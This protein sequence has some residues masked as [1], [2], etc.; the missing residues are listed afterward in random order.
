MDTPYTDA[1][2][3]ICLDVLQHVS[4]DTSLVDEDERFKALVAKIRKS[5]KRRIQTDKKQRQTSH[6]RQLMES[7]VRC[8][9]DPLN[10]R[11][12]I[13]DS[14]SSLRQLLKKRN[15]YVCK[16]AYTDVHFRYHLLCPMCSEENEARRRIDV[17]LKGRVALVT[18]GRIK[19][20]FHTGLYL[21]R[22]CA[23]VHIT[24]RFPDHALRSYQ[25]EDDY[26]SWCD[27][28]HVHGLDLRNIPRVEEFASWLDQEV[29]CLDILINNAAQTVK[30][31]VGYYAD[32]LREE[33]GLP[34]L[35]EA[36]TQQA[37]PMPEA[38][39]ALFPTGQ[40]DSEGQQIDLRDENSWS[41]RLDEVGVAELLEV[42]LVNSIAP[43]LLAARLT[44][45]LARSLNNRRF[46][47]N[48]SAMEGNFHWENKTG[49]HPHTNMAKAALNML[50]RTCAEDYAKAGIYVNSV[51]TGWIT[52]EHPF[53]VGQR[54][55]Q[56]GFVPPLD[57]I[58]GAA[59]IL[60]PVVD[61]IQKEDTPYHGHFLKDYHPYP[62]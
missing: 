4:E 30:R 7:T 14:S 8:Q 18:G 23:E 10:G 19:I 48:V 17:D 47:V 38:T 46:I 13:D 33:S 61:G 43:C 45:T 3:Q 9:K 36:L 20:G 55:R 34:V 24:T 16:Q 51:D 2:Y 54:L 32:I 57:V 35:L 59:R 11:P 29:S 22:N 58:D 50:T 15:C 53:H 31:P 52:Q 26:D 37:L 25:S 27:R 28:L 60:A 40:R 21:L 56:G 1:E 44:G 6:D 49:R 5:A 62:W 39:N 42:H 41:A 12:Q